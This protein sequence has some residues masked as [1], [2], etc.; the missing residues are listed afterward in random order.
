MIRIRRELHRNPEVGLHTPFTR[1]VI[2]RELEALGI[3]PTL[4]ERTTGVVAVVGT[5]LEGPVTLLRAD[6]DGLPLMERTDLDF[7]A[8]TG[9]MHACGHDLHTAMLLGG[10]RLLVDRA[11]ALPG[12]VVL[13]FQPGEESYGGAVHMIEEGV[14]DAAGRPAARA[15]AIHVFSM[16]ESGAV[17]LNAGPMMAASDQVHLTVFGSGGHGSSPHLA[18]DPVPVAAEMI[19][20]IQTAMT[21]SVSAMDPAVVTFGQI[22]AGSAT[23]IIPESV[24]MHGTIRTLSDSVRSTVHSLIDRVATGVASAHGCRVQATIDPGYPVTINDTTESERIAGVVAGTL[25]PGALVDAPPL[26]VAEDW[27]YVLN[28]VP[29]VMA[30]LGARPDDVAES[31]MNHSDL[32][33]FA[34]GAMPAGA[35]LYAAAAG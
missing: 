2:V 15:F 22:S 33:V 23:N 34:E 4:H 32:V 14:I 25:G 35:A 24:E 29:G 12:P 8:T 16:F 11:D 30:L 27:S 3:E 1:S 13:M 9:T 21:R 5:E 7:A 10:A 20:A 28:R 26:M 19:L 18:L 17:V 31:P 6:H